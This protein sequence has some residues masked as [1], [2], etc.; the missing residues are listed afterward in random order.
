MAKWTVRI[1]VTVSVIAC[2][3]AV[4]AAVNPSPLAG[5][6]VS[7]FVLELLSVLAGDYANALLWSFT[8]VFALCFARLVWRHT[9][10]VPGDRW[11]RA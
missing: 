9:V 5:R 11:W 1:C 8:A 7:R 3:A 2:I 4:R 6:G 10:K